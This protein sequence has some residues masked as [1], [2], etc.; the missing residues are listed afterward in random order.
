M[1]TVGKAAVILLG[2]YVVYR[3]GYVV[4]KL[5]MSKETSFWGRF[6]FLKD[7][8]VNS[9][10]AH[11]NDYYND[12]V[13]SDAMNG[14]EENKNLPSLVDKVCHTFTDEVV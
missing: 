2:T 11:Y 3:G 9:E 7:S 12:G 10:I 5:F 6:G 13:S 4:L 14:D 8:E 1:V